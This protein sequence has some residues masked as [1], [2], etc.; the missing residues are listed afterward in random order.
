MARFQFAMYDNP[1]SL[2]AVAISKTVFPGYPRHPS[3]E[4]SRAMKEKS[5]RAPRRRYRSGVWTLHGTQT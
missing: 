5:H 4:N 1:N 3:P 2:P